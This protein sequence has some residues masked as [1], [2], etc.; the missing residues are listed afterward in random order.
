M[1]NSFIKKNI[2]ITGSNSRFA[3]SL[4]KSFNGKNI[5]YTDRKELDILD[6]RS[7]DKSFDK[8]KPNYLI[9]LAS[10]SRPMIVHEEDINSSI[11]ANI[12]GTANIVKKCSDRNI[13]LIYFSTN[14]VYPGN[15]GNYDEKD[16]LN[17]VNNYAWSK[18]GGE[19]S[20]KLYK[21]SL[22]LRLAMT[23]YPFIHDKA[24]TDAKTNFIYREEVI[25]ILPYLLDEKG[26][27]NVGSDITESFYSF[28]KKTKKDV[29]PISV[30]NIKNFPINSSVKINKLKK[31]LK[32]KNQK[33]TDRQNI[34]K[35]IIKKKDVYLTSGPSVTQIEREIVDDMMRFGW[36][37][38]NYVKKFEYNFAKYHK[39]KYCILT[40]SI[41]IAYHLGLKG[42]NLKRNSRVIITDFSDEDFLYQ[43]L[44]MKLKP[45]ITNINPENLTIDIE[46]LKKLLK[47][48]IN[49]IFCPYLLGAIPDF[50]KLKKILANKKVFLLEDASDALGIKINDSLSGQFGDISFHNFSN[51]KMITSGEGGAILTNNKIIY[52]NIKKLINPG[53]KFLNIKVHDTNSN[54][55]LCFNP[56]NLQ[57]AMLCGQLKRLNNLK[58]KSNEIKEEY[59]KNL[60]SMNVSI[61]GYRLIAMKFDKI[62]KTRLNSLI[63]YLKEENIHCEKLQKPF[64]KLNYFKNK[65][66]K[67]N[68][69]YENTIILPSHYNLNITDIKH[70]CSKIKF[71]LNKI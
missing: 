13:K 69:V 22:I 48:K 5:I 68:K 51:D 28:A 50:Q 64:S 44:Q 56:T 43:L 33:I 20:V 11:D 9:H 58:T 62:K 10:L 55:K 4:K 2:L 42:I 21:N 53:K 41:G 17:P 60:E 71:F 39:R 36:D 24:F 30:K 59:Q 40:P 1:D 54:T 70:I 32:I 6:L 45:I 7:I 8:Y 66:I 37:N 29:K 65:F 18:L 34:K 19:A 47:K 38:F 16:D 31:I 67:S 52:S 14:Y 61:I 46:F 3:Q 49:A 23:E 57:A 25:K 27:I 63:K 12:I 15:K 35:I 26:I